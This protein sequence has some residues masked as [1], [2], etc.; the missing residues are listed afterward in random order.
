M[1]LNV[2]F[3]KEVL[4]FPQS[5]RAALQGMHGA[6]GIAEMVQNMAF[7]IFWSDLGK[8]NKSVV[9]VVSVGIL[10]PETC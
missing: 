8:K 9:L 5:C 10:R 6:T 7:C 3:T 1:N 4:M 2:K